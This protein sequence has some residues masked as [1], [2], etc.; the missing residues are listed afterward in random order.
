[1]DVRNLITLVRLVISKVFIKAIFWL[2]ILIF[3]ASLLPWTRGIY[4]HIFPRPELR[5]TESSASQD[6]QTGNEWLYQRVAVV[7]NRG[8]G[9]ANQ[10]YVTASLPGGRINK[11]EVFADHP[12][13]VHPN[14]DISRGYL[15]LALDRLSP[16]ARI[17][18][19]LWG[20][21]VEYK[22]SSRVFAAVYDAGSAPSTGEPSSEEQIR[23]FIDM[24]LANFEESL[25]WIADNVIGPEGIRNHE[26]AFGDISIPIPQVPSHLVISAITLAVLAWLFLDSVHAALVHGCLV[27]GMCWLLVPLTVIPSMFMILCTIPFLLLLALR[28]GSITLLLKQIVELF[29]ALDWEPPWE[30]PLDVESQWMLSLSVLFLVFILIDALGVWTVTRDVTDCITAGYLATMLSLELL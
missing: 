10:V 21:R 19:Y 3:I 7:E 29:F 4:D 24:I 20:S 23:G 16:G 15:V 22:Q 1:M 2:A 26:L 25:T 9:T 14:T 13:T 8:N 30:K 5:I 28:T 12:Y 11:Y 17:T 27:S 18:V 6:S